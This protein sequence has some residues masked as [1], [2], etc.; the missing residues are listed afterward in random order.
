MKI[1][2]NFGENRL[3]FVEKW[4]K[5]FNNC[6]HPTCK[7]KK[8]PCKVLLAWIKNEE[9]FEIFKKILRFFDQ[10]LYGNLTFLTIRF[11]TTYFLEFYILSESILHPWKITSV[12]YTSGTFRLP[13]SPRPDSTESLATH[14]KWPRILWMEALLIVPCKADCLLQSKGLPATYPM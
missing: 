14:P 4:K 11:F 10:N 12:F 6:F 2:E 5:S 9:N 1:I 13:P 3:E 7:S 8:G